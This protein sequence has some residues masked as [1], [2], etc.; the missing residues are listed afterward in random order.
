ML[1]VACCEV[2]VYS[3]WQLAAR[4]PILDPD[5]EN[6]N[7]GLRLRRRTRPRNQNFFEDED[8]KDPIRSPDLALKPYR[9]LPS[10]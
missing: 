9:Q 10:F 2:R 5:K 7:H 3:C 1:R 6:R 4:S 8:E